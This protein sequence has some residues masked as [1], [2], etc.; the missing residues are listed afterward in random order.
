MMVSAPISGTRGQIVGVMTSSRGLNSAKSLYKVYIDNPGFGYTHTSPPSVNF[1][2]GN[3]YGA[4]V[5]IA[6]ST[7]GGIGTI[8]VNYPGTGYTSP[9]TITFSSP[10]SG[11]T[12]AIADAF[13]N[14]NGEVSEIRI[15]NAGAGYT[16]APTITVSAG[17][18][19]ASGNYFFGESVTGSISGAIGIVKDWDL[20]TN[21]LKVSGMGT[22]FVN[23][24]VV[25]G[26]QS[27]AIRIIGDY[28]T[29]DLQSP[30]DDSDDIEEEADKIIDFTELNPFGEA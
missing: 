13:L 15:V 22:D 26:K 14:D 6:R 5:Q 7:S 11:G 18:T 21:Q 20:A 25:I 23:G 8:T 10:V 12:T 1:F 24:D 3:G 4:S 27:G 2:G 19:I 9:P 16:Q 29:Y 17:S 30:Y 28:Q